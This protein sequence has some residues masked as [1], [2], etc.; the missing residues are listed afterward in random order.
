M[1]K[2]VFYSL[3]AIMMATAT[4]CNSQKKDQTGSPTKDGSAK[5]EQT[6]G[7]EQQSDPIRNQL[8]WDSPAAPSNADGEIERI[9]LG[10]TRPDGKHFDLTTDLTFPIAA[11]QFMGGDTKEADINFDGIPDLQVSL[12]FVDGFGSEIFDAWTWDV[13]KHE[14]VH[15]E[16]Y[17]EIPNPEIDAEKKCIMS[18]TRNDDTLE[19]AEYQWKDGKLTL[20]DRRTEEIEKGNSSQKNAQ[21]MQAQALAGEWRW[22]DDGQ[23]PSKIQLILSLDIE[24]STL[25]CSEAT[26]YGSNAAFKTGLRLQRRRAHAHR[27]TGTGRRLVVAR[28]KAEAQRAWRPVRHIRLHRG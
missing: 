16:G 3:V 8:K 1:K 19:V 23:V 7:S 6:A 17:S 15:V 24:E 11:E 4:S 12:G 28:R 10:Y 22:A 5:T 20:T 18:Y 25:Y 14:F 13:E 9:Y 2:Q 27:R 21:A 26:I